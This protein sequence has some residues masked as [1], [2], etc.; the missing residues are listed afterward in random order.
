MERPLPDGG[1]G[2]WNSDAGETAATIERGLPD[3]SDGIWN[4]DAGETA[5]TIERPLR[6]A[7][8]R[9]WN[10]I[11]VYGPWNEQYCFHCFVKK[12]SIGAG[13]CFTILP[14]IDFSK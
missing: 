7:C 11:L 9:I 1:D 5:A 2:I 4:G 13:K 6:D 12:N 14:Y 8:D 10:G 3:A